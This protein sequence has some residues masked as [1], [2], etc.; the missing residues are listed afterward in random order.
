MK[1]CIK[2]NK[3]KL[4]KAFLI[5]HKKYLNSYCKVCAIKLKKI[6]MHSKNGKI[7]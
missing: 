5:V 4:D 1:K 3:Y 6:Y 2:C 7:I